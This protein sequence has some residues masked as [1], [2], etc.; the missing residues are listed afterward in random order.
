MG[1]SLFR[2]FNIPP[3]FVGLFNQHNFIAAIGQC[4]SSGHTGQPAADD[5]G[6][7]LDFGSDRFLGFEQ[8][9]FGHAHTDQ[10]LGLGI[11]VC[12]LLHV[13]PGALISDVDH[14]EKIGIQPC[15]L[16]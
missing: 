7:G 5:Q 16:A 1:P 4:C 9:C 15:F 14:L 12:L 10:I 3:Q 8:S 11:C 2:R 13:D 6:T